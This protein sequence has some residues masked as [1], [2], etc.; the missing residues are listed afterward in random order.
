[1]Y[2]AKRSG[3][4]AALVYD[5]TMHTE[6]MDVLELGSDLYHAVARGELRLQYQPVVN[7]HT[8]QPERNGVI[9]EIGHWVLGSGCTQAAI[10]R[11]FSLPDL[12][13]SVNVSARQLDDLGFAEMVT[14]HSESGWRSTTLAL[15]THR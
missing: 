5:P 1:M 4:R 9:V 13:I 3:A 10:W 14:E 6:T 7:L 15:A 2:R 12:A 11:P 8:G